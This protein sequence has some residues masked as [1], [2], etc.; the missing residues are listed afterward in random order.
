VGRGLQPETW[1]GE[2]LAAHDRRLAGMT[3]PPQGLFLLRV[4][5]AR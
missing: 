5:Y 4:E 3:A 1:P 2:V